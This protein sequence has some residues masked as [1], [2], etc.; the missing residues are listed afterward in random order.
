MSV[1]AEFDAWAADGRDRGMEQ[2]HWRTAK[3]VLARMPVE[4]GE[5]VLDLGCGSGYA[6]RPLRDAK[7]TGRACGIDGAPEMV[8]NARECT[9]D[10]RVLLVL[11]DFGSLPFAD[12]SVDHVFSMRAGETITYSSNSSAT[13][14]GS[15]VLNSR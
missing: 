3:H 1:R 9:D 14:A 7:D 12:E 6:A 8:G 15:S 11:G 13:S 4:T 5:A 2:R 10:P